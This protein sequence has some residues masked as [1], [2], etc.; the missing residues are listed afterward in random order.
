MGSVAL[1]DYQKMLEEF[2]QADTNGDGK[3]NKEEFVFFMSKLFW[4]GYFWIIFREF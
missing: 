2:K 4:L 3:V 1:E